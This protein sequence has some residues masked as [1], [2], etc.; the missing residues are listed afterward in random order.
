MNPFM[1]AQGL[2]PMQMLMQRAMSD[3]R[4]ANNPQAQE[5]VRVLQSGDQ[6]AGEQ[7]AKNYLQSLGISQEDAISQ[8]QQFLKQQFGF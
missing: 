2:D 8:S 3:P 5:I 1:K 6:Q 7:L 4:L